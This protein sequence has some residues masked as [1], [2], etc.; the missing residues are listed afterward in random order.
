VRP[1]SREAIMP[2]QASGFLRDSFGR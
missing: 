2:R 1:K